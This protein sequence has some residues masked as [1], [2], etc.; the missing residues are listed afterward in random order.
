MVL[1]LSKLDLKKKKQKFKI[2]KDRSIIKLH[3]VVVEEQEV[4]EVVHSYCHQDKIRL[5]PYQKEPI[6]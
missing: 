5:N 6:K 3:E 2:N 4:V 1:L